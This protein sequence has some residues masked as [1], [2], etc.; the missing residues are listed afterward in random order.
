ME[1]YRLERG[2]DGRPVVR[3]PLRGFDLL[4]HPL[5]NKGSAFT[6]AE[7]AAFGLEGLVP[8]QVSSLR[9]QQ[10]R[11]YENIKRKTDP[12]EQYIGL[13]ALQDRNTHLFYRLMVD[14]IDEFL[15]IMYT[16]TVGQV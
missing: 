7:R 15:P 4:N 2:V 1:S 10:R 14:H 9:N 6:R 5:Y 3:V 16:P 11:I 13:A 8:H 12:V